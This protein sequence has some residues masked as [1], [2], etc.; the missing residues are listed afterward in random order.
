[1]SR[2]QYQVAIFDAI[3]G[4]ASTL[5]RTLERKVLELDVDPSELRFFDED[6]AAAIDQLLPRVGVLFSDDERG[7]KFAPAVTA[8]TENAAVVIPAVHSV[9]DFASK[10]PESL[11]PVNALA[12][13]R[14]DEQLE[15]VAS[16]VLEL[17]GLLRNRR[18]VFISYKRVE[19]A[20]VALQLHHQLDARAFEV[21]LDTLSVRAA[22]TFQETLWHRMADSDLVV[23]LYTRSVLESG[24]VAQE[25]ERANGMGISVLQVIWPGVARDRRTDLFEPFYLRK[26]DFRLWRR[27]SLNDRTASEIAV[28]VEKLRARSLA[29][30]EAKLVGNLCELARSRRIQPVVQRARYVDLL[31]PGDG[32]VTRVIPALG[33]PDAQAVQR[34]TT[35]VPPPK[36]PESIVLLYDSVSVANEWLGHLAWLDRYLPVKTVK[37]ADLATWLGTICP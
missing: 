12:L 33:V 14:A 31:C 1:M 20:D 24:W 32:P 34:C 23:L 4:C 37:T 15:A 7:Q 36:A 2:A 16:L 13:D 9:E 22:D 6:S 11:R 18:R 17:F 35:F 10:V 28:A 19:S 5:R 26:R 27:R 30:R 25:L 29:A 8:L 3:G 21:F